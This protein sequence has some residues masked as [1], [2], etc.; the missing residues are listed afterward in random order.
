M[1]AKRWV[2]GSAV[3]AA[4]IGAAAA[5]SV[6]ESGAEAKARAF[7]SRFPL[8]SSLTDVA[9]AARDAGDPKHRL[10]RAGEISIAYI[11][12]PPFSR[13]VC[14]FEGESGKVTKARYVHLD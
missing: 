4:V 9:A 7:C 6:V 3:L 8:G 1:R 2:L 12:V 11:G 13:H 10:I 5:V 14:A